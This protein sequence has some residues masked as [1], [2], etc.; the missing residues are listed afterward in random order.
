MCR[1]ADSGM[2]MLVDGLVRGV[3]VIDED[4]IHVGHAAVV[5]DQ[6]ENVVARRHDVQVAGREES[7]AAGVGAA[8]QAG[9][10]GRRVAEADRR[11][12]AI[13]L[14]RE[15]D[16]RVDAREGR[17]R[18]EVHPGHRRDEVGRVLALDQPDAGGV[19]D[20]A[21]GVGVGPGQDEVARPGHEEAARPAD[22]AAERGRVVDDEDG[23]RRARRSSA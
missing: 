3:A 18:E 6:L 1:P 16:R 8:R 19:E 11:D 7:V 20:G 17:R 22:G 2:A 9:R 4:A 12:E 5:A 15:V 14:R 13:R 10:V 23:R 21:A